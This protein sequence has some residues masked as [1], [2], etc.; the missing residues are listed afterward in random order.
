VPEPPVAVV[1]RAGT[2]T[3]FVE[4]PRGI[5][6]HAY[7]YDAEGRVAA[8]N[9]VTPTALN[10]ASVEDRFRAVVARDPEAADEVL[11]RR[12][13]MVARAYDPCISCAVHLVRPRGGRR[14]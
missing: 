5:L 8:A 6:L 11:S 4:A 1:P 2:G 14:R 12:L 10:A 7:T 13:E 9:V 3:A